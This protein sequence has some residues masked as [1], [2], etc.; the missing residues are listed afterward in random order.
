MYII[1][2]CNATRRRQHLLCCMCLLS[3]MTLLGTTPKITMT[4]LH[5]H[6]PVSHFV[7]ERRESRGHVYD[8]AVVLDTVTIHGW[9]QIMWSICAQKSSQ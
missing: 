1:L 2:E 7:V 4:T 9:Q 6:M 8:C 5:A 3:Y